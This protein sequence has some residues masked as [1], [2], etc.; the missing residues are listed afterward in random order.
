MFTPGMFE[1]LRLS[2][3]G[4][5]LA[6]LYSQHM[7]NNIIYISTYV[8][9][10]TYVNMSTSN[11]FL[12]HLQLQSINAYLT[13]SLSQIHPKLTILHFIQTWSISYA[14]NFCL[15]CW[16]CAQCFC[17]C[18]LLCSKLCWHNRLK[19]KPG[20]Q[21]HLFFFQNFLKFLRTILIVCN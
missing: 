10:K 4:S 2:Y 19:P 17:Q 1:K 18:S 14:G 8:I 15:L 16:H 6:T 11:S 7:I 5:C 20:L 13:K 9:M 21:F 3:H 12:L